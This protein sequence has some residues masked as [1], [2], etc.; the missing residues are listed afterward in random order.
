MQYKKRPKKQN[1]NIN[2]NEILISDRIDSNSKFILNL[3]LTHHKEVDK[4][5]YCPIYN[6]QLAS[7]IGKSVPTFIKYRDILEELKLIKITPIKG[8]RKNSPLTYYPQW[9][10]LEN[11]NFI[12][13]IE[14][15]ENDKK[16]K[17]NFKKKIP[18]MTTYSKKSLE[19]RGVIT[20]ESSLKL[21]DDS[22]YNIEIYKIDSQGE[23]LGI[24]NKK[25][26]YGKDLKRALKSQDNL[27]Q[28]GNPRELEYIL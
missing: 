4:R 6:K 10:K 7:A 17:E 16:Y 27:E 11:W 12:K 3:I 22:L 13:P 15:S 19:D 8:K 20:T 21:S 28:I 5:N 26:M 24:S 18:N 1:F 14:L 9:V 23:R 25:N 2:T